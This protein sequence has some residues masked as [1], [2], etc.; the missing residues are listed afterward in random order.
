MNIN[1]VGKDFIFEFS[2]DKY[3][4]WTFSFKSIF[5]VVMLFI[6]PMIGYELYQ[7]TGKDFNKINL[8]IALLYFGSTFI[9]Y[10]IFY[11]MWSPKPESHVALDEDEEKEGLVKK[12]E[13]S[14]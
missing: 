7:W 9:F 6:S 10:I 5:A 2:H 14:N 1:S 12:E 8:L 3:V 4:Q 13:K 11:L